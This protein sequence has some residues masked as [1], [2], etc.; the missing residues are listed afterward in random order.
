MSRIEM[1]ERARAQVHNLWQCNQEIVICL[2]NNN[3]ESVT[4][5]Y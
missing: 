4:R 3:M 2:G 1:A 5:F